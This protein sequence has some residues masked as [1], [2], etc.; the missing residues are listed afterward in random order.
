M[1]PLVALQIPVCGYIRKE[2]ALIPMQDSL[3][4]LAKGYQGSFIWII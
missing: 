1:R 2:K 3:C 4:Q